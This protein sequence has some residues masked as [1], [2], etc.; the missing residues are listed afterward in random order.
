MKN[1]TKKRQYESYG[2][3]MFPRKYYFMQPDSYIFN[4]RV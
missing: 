2:L 4:V 1:Y 3:N